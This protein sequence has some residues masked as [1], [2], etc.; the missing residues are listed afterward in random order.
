MPSGYVSYDLMYKREIKQLTDLSLAAR[1]TV[2]SGDLEETVGVNLEC[3]DKLGLA[4]GHGGNTGEL[5]LAE[6]S[7][8]PALSTLTLVPVWRVRK[9]RNIWCKGLRTQGK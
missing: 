3:G 7:V 5:E 8:V 9:H 1:S 2:L 6:E 4:T